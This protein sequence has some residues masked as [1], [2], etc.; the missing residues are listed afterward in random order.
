[1]GERIFL[2]KNGGQEFSY[3]K[4]GRRVFPIQNGGQ[5]FSL[6][7]IGDED[8][9]NSKWGKRIFPIQNGGQELFYNFKIGCPGK[10]SG[11]SYHSLRTSYHPK[12]KKTLDTIDPGKIRVRKF[13]TEGLTIS[14]H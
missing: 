5:G 14:G 7:E 11:K 6:Y 2:I 13:K 3:S 1:M 8:F 9:P 12:I 10:F 4:W